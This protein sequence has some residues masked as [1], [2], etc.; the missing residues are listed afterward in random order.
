M[1]RIIGIDLGTT[2]SLVAHDDGSGPLVIPL[3]SGDLH[4]PSVVA[5]EEGQG[6][7]IGK[8]ARDGVALRPEATI[9]SSKRHMGTERVYCLGEEQ[10]RPQDVAALILKELRAAAEGHFRA[11][12]DRAVVSVP[13]YFND[14]GR[15]A[16]REA[17]EIAGLKIERLVSEPTAAALAYGIDRLGAEEYLLVYDLGGGTFDVSVL[18]TFEGIFNVRAA[19]GD[20]RLGGDDFDGRLL[21]VVLREAAAPRAEDLSAGA[22]ARLR[23]AVERAK[24]ELSTQEEAEVRLDMLALRDGSFRDLSMTVTRAAFEDAT[25]DLLERTTAA[26]RTALAEAHVPLEKVSEVILV[27]GSTRMPMVRGHLTRL[28]GRPPRDTVDP[29]QAV[30]LG[31]AIQARLVD[32]P[33]RAQEVVVTDV[34]PFTLGVAAVGELGGEIRPGVFTPLIHRNT[35]LPAKRSQVFTTLHPEQDTIVVE[36]YQGDDAVVENNVFLD[37][38]YLGGVPKNRERPEPVEITFEYDV[39]GILRVNAVVLA[40][41]KSAGIRID[42]ARMKAVGHGLAASTAKVDGLWRRSKDREKLVALVDACRK[43]VPRLEEP[44]RS[45]LQARI[46]EA[47]EALRKGDHARIKELAGELAHLERSCSTRGA[48]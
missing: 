19:S 13:A 24:I 18:E 31:A 48:D 7:V 32:S 10:L 17:A 6:L 5:M 22:L 38:Y 2:N 44:W 39:D 15:R 42:P 33:E 25:R 16:T 4:L 34:S 11:P 20:A 23:V 1:G 43:H 29:M 36:V 46:E 28:F 21:G 26:L 9:A 12:V 35:A 8:A 27:G 41:G 37:R 47:S 45:R 14:V 30:A 3:S 40:T